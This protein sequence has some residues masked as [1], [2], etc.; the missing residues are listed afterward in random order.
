M[1]VRVGV[2]VGVVRVCG[3]IWT[4][5]GS[6]KT[7]RDEQDMCMDEAVDTCVHMRGRADTIWQ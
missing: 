5:Y 1:S 6:T 7:R 4:A 2:L 3:G